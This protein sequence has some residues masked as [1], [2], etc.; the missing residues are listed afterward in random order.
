V[1]VAV[2]AL[3]FNISLQGQREPIV[4][5]VPNAQAQSRKN[6]RLIAHIE[7]DGLIFSIAIDA[8]DESFLRIS[9]PRRTQSYTISSLPP[10]RIKVVM[11][12][13]AIIEGPADRL[14]GAISNGGW[15]DIR[16]R[17]ALRKRAVVDD[18]RSVT[19]WIGDQNY[20]AFTF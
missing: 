13:D 12:D 9:I 8:A 5:S 18:I 11:A 17:F 19:I 20:T 4:Q 1:V 14:S 2:A 10:V 15:D 3:A 16:Y 7:H 6:A